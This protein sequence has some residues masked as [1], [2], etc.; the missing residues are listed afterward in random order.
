MKTSDFDYPFDESL[1]A[2]YPVKERDLS[3]LMV[4][5]AKD[6]R[7]EHRI[8]RDITDY[9]HEGDVLVFNITKVIPARLISKKEKTG[10]KVEIL[11]SKFIDDYTVEA[12][13]NPGRKAKTGEIL[14]IESVKM[15]II[16]RNDEGLRIIKM[17]D[18]GSFYDV[19]D[20]Y[21]KPPIP[22]YL[23][24][25]SEE[26]DRERYQSVFA[27]IEGSC[28]AP[29]ASLHFTPELIKKI[30]KMGVITTDV[31]LHV[32][33]GTFRPVKTERIEDH[34]MHTEYYKVFEETAEIINRAKKEGR[35]IFAVGTTSVRVLESSSTEEG[36]LLPGEGET[37]IFIYPP[38][39]FKIVD[40]LITNFHFPR[41]TLV[42]L[43]CALG[44]KETILNAYRTA[45]EKRYRFYSYGDSMLILNR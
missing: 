25:E 41:S 9:L 22:P 27:R 42:M 35:R 11:I 10:G 14:E 39:K 6:N 37:D 15:K 29:T 36:V 34:K 45:V 1:I 8:F 24:R 31:L 16:D 3:K 28:A 33:I 30:Q 44:G 12:M 19:I 13:V 38:Y 18:G 17:I 20:K 23:K 32:G 2:K 26:I 40:N 43:V 7:I 5:H 4:V 21:G